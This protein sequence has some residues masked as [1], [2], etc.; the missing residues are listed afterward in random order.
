MPRTSEELTR[1]FHVAADHPIAAHPRQPPRDRVQLR[2]TLVAE[3]VGEF[4]GA[5]LGYDH[6][7]AKRAGKIL[8]EQFARWEKHAFETAGDSVGYVSDIVGVGKEGCDVHVVTSGTLIEYGVPEDEIYEAVHVSNMAKI[9]PDGGAKRPDGKTLKPAGWQPPDVESI[10]FPGQMKKFEVFDRKTGRSFGTV[11]CRD[12]DEA[13]TTVDDHH[14]DQQAISE[15][16]LYAVEAG[17]LPES[18]P[19]RTVS[20][21]DDGTPEAKAAIER[22][23]ATGAHVTVFPS[24]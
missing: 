23:R 18:S 9:G 24:E 6:A 10:V 7:T 1:E 14:E 8:S 4:V 2:L 22:L 21:I 19:V 15:A 3:E 20:V 11:R 13:I 16:D 17:K 12:E 5:M